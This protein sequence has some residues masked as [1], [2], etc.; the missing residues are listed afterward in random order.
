MDFQHWYVIF[1]LTGREERVKEELER[2]LEKHKDVKAC[3]FIP[4]RFIRELKDGKWYEVERVMFPG[5]VLVGTEGIERVFDVALGVQ[6]KLRFLRSNDSDKDFQEVRLDEISR[7]VYMVDERGVI[8][9]SEV[10]LN[11][12]GRA[13]VLSGP[14]KGEEGHI[15][16]F[17]R[18]KGRVRIAFLI[19]NERHEIWLAV[20]LAKRK[21]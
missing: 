13:V 1:V 15:T 14:L 10:T 4:K 5:Y 16:K 18:R 19:G 8:G 11:G 3:F 21:G 12:D 2:Q 6:G 17:D 7:L 20:R 9:E